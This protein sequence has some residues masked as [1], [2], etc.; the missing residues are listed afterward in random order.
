MEMNDEVEWVPKTRLGVMVSRG[1]IT[2]IAEVF[3]RGFRIMEP[4][5][6]DVLLPELKEE[7]LDITMV[8]RMHKSGRRMR[9]RATVAIGNENGYV[10]VGKGV[11]KEVGPAIRKAIKDAKLNIIQVARGCGSW[12]CGC[13]TWHSVP[14]A[15]TGRAGSVRITLLPAPR[16]T[17]LV[18]NDVSKKILSLAG[19]SD[20]WSKAFGEKRTTINTTRA[21]YEALRNTTR[22]KLSEMTQKAVGFTVGEVR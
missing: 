11:A 10:G 20:V 12:E 3:R 8:Q 21:T 6:V 1:E 9:F 16:G 13:G 7:V 4:E 18:T 17:G 2:D 14:F 22:M 15:V 19:I 5:I